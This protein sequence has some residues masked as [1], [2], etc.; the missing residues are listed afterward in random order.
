[1][2]LRQALF[3]GWGVRRRLWSAL[4][5]LSIAVL[6]VGG[7]TLVSLQ[8]VDANLQELHRQT[9]SEV[10]QALELSRRS[11]NLAT[12]APYLLNQRSNFLLNQEASRLLETLDV[13]RVD[14]PETTFVLDGR[15][16]TDVSGA[17]DQIAEAVT[18]LVAA[19]AHLDRQRTAIRA[20]ATALQDM[21]G[22]TM[23]RIAERSISNDER[24]D[25]W[26]LQS[27]TADA[28]T[29]VYLGNL[30]GVGEAQ[31]A[32]LRQNSLLAD[33]SLT[34]AQSAY[35][36]QLD[37]VA[38]GPLGLFE[39]RRLE[40]SE[41]LNAQNAL[42][43]IRLAASRISDLASTYAEEAET[44]L[45]RERETASAVIGRTS[46]FVGAIVLASLGLALASAIYVSRYVTFNISRVSSAMVQ[47]ASGDRSS[48]LPRRGAR[49][50]EI[51]ALF[52][53][54]RIF[55]ANALRLDR[56]NRQ[57]DAR[58]A[59]FRKV[60]ANM[61]DGIA[62]VDAMGRVTAS[63]PAL[64][65]MLGTFN[66]SIAMPARLHAAGLEATEKAPADLA[67]Y[68]PVTFARGRT[69]IV[70]IR[71]SHLPEGGQVWLLT[72][73]TEQRRLAERVQ[74]I[75]R[76]ETLGKVT[77]DAAHDFG[78]ILSTISTHAHLL[79]PHLAPVGQANLAAIGNAVEFGSSLT[80]RL[81]A[82]ARKQKLTPEVVELGELLDGLADLLEIGLK[83]GVNLR[84]E[85]PEHPIR[86]TV[87]PGQLESTLLN[88]VLNANQAIERDGTVRV[89][90]S[91]GPSETARIEVTDDG[92]GM[93]T[94]TLA[95]AV[96]PFY[97]TRG[98]TGGTGLGLSIVYGFIK[99][100]GGDIQ[101]LSEPDIGTTVRLSLPIQ[102][103]EHPSRA[104]NC[105]VG[106][107]LI[108]EDDAETRVLLQ[109]G[110]RSTAA[111]VQTAANGVEAAARLRA[112][113]RPD[114]LVTDID[115]GAGPNGWQLARDMLEGSP[116]G[117]VI[118]MSGKMPSRIPLPP[119]LH[120]RI[121]CLEKPL[122]PDRLLAAIH[123]LQSREYQE[124]AQDI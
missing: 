9:L 64:D 120:D 70:D 69:L 95:H 123:R 25:W 81:L 55:R 67:G 115:L 7:I 90:V 66:G 31:R 1:M 121:L 62:V 3:H 96:E 93:D 61:S 79:A 47:L 97:T 107:V 113:G 112:D 49:E 72:D 86:V 27:M 94:P 5:L 30:I 24:L 59:L 26:T 109:D 22:E 71:V 108:A 43:R 114:L 82:F 101:I 87:D 6:T 19:T 18:D 56:T 119:A 124:C 35:L 38:F 117:L 110:L 32:Y 53:S 41:T 65:R 88:L 54:F 116:A 68:G 77:G 33:R 105:T 104:T 98:E 37:S 52:K 11:A 44:Y 45:A 85:T 51:G 99:Q 122:Q 111:L 40:L 17:V 84:I 76:I 91:Q 10:A 58:N 92:C 16:R 83:S 74:Q 21:R 34:E 50:D 89:T 73:V 60:F 80:G 20:T 13:I 39:R 23:E 2:S 29:A 8:R 42:F 106:R 48:S 118:V 14:W 103:K 36:V 63:N 78:N 57:L 100:T 46:A 15:T 12:S 28:L 102:T 4:A 75:D